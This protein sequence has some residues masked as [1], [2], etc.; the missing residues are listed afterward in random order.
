MKSKLFG[1]LLLILATILFAGCTTVKY[2]D[3]QQYMLDIKTPAK[4]YSRAA[5][6]TLEINNVSI[7]A[8][9]TSLEFVYRTTNENYTRDYYSIF[10]NPPAQQLNRVIARYLQATNLFKYV[11]T[12]PGII[13]TDYILYPE[14]TELYADYRNPNNP[15]AIMTIRFTIIKT[16]NPSQPMLDQTFHEEIPFTS[17]KPASLVAAWDQGLASILA[18]LSKK[19]S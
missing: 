8:A 6:R 13:Q 17:G 16:A 19:L 10:F 18:D 4:I 2:P 12:N 3:R 5:T 11:S 14:V 7:A 1:S 15:R 9:Y